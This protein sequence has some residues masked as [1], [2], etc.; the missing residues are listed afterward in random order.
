MAGRCGVDNMS[1]DEAILA[2][3]AAG[4]SPPTVRLYAWDPPSVSL[5]YFQEPAED[6]VDLAECGRRGVDVVRRTTGGGA[7][8][9]QHEVTYSVCLPERLVPA[10]D[11]G[12]SYAWICGAIC[13]GLAALGAGAQLR[14]G[15]T[16][17]AEG[18][19]STEI[20]FARGSRFDVVTGGRKLVGSAQRRIK[21]A[22]LQHGSV[23]LSVDR[24]A[25]RALFPSDPGYGGA[26]WGLDEVLGRTVS[27]E[28][29]AGAVTAG[30]GE[31]A[32]GDGGLEPGELTGA[33]E[34]AAARLRDER[35][36]DADWTIRGTPRRRRGA[37]AHIRV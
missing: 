28:E 26:F 14:G 12:A 27:P 13:R 20:C 25:H 23:L 9:H 2:A 31:I 11:V 8:L 22:M 5:G 17:G 34:T 18:E 30:L 15:E 32:C 4:G 29:A 16:D 24:E 37:N 36:S 10:G 1:V 6:V 21:G 3:V 33:E 35:Y 19:V 7:I